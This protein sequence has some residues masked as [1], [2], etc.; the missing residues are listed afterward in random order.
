MKKRRRN[1]SAERESSAESSNQ[2][3][4]MLT[5][6]ANKSKVV[7]YLKRIGSNE[8]LLRLGEGLGLDSTEL[9]KKLTSDTFLDD[10]VREWLERKDRV[11]EVGTPSWRKLV[12]VLQEVRQNG[13]ANDIKREQY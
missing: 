13:L 5:A 3:I 7:Q 11:D 1:D 9:R 2:S 10:M 12:E 8:D 4:S 6:Q